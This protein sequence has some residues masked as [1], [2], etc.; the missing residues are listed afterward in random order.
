MLDPG[1]KDSRDVCTNGVRRGV[2]S[3]IMTSTVDV[4]Q[5]LSVC[6]YCRWRRSG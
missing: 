4:K 5:Y 2:H 6:L 1:G 3:P